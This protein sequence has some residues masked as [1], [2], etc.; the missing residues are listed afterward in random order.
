MLLYESKKSSHTC[1]HTQSQ[2]SVTQDMFMYVYISAVQTSSISAAKCRMYLCR[3]FSSVPD[4]G[5][6]IRTRNVVG[7]LVEFKHEIMIGS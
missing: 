6:E 2:P 7:L 3:D 4:A 1:L 5:W